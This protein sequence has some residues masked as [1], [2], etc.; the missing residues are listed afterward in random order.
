MCK[1][2]APS[3]KPIRDINN[4]HNNSD[5]FFSFTRILA[6][7]CAVEI[8]LGFSDGLS[9]Y[10]YF[11]ACVISFLDFILKHLMYNLF[12]FSNLYFL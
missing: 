8:A 9:V 1:K 2:L 11:S 5:S 10:H 3:L 12:G 6:I 4:N 7:A